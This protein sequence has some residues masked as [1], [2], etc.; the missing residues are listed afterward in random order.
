MQLKA[1]SGPS[2]ATLDDGMVASC[3]LGEE[4]WRWAAA[5]GKD[6]EDEEAASA[7]AKAMSRRWRN[8]DPC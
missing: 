1:A 3:T 2:A 4:M 6:E 8:V 5:S 7:G